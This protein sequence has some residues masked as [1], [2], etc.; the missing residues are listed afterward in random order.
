M[1]PVSLSFSIGWVLS[2]GGEQAVAL[3]PPEPLFDPPLPDAPE[4]VFPPLP[5]CPP[6]PTAPPEADP[7]LPLPPDPLLAPPEPLPDPPLPLTFPPLL[8]QAG[9]ANPTASTAAK[10]AR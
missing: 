6:D 4:P 9:S 7:P 2:E 10:P 5:T 3:P 8:L 1:H